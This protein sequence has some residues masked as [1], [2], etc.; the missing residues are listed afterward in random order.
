MLRVTSLTW[1]F[2]TDFGDCTHSDDVEYVWS[3]I[4][5]AILKAM[6]IYIPKVRLTPRKHPNWYNPDIRLMLNCIRTLRRKCNKHPTSYNLSK[7]QNLEKQLQNKLMLA[8][9]TY[10]KNLIDTF[11]KVNS[12][13]IYKYIHSLTNHGT[14]PPTVTFDSS[15][16]AL[17]GDKASM[18]NTFF[19]SVFTRSLFRLPPLDELPIPD[20]TITDIS[21]SESDVHEA[22]SSLNTT[23]AMGIDGIGPKLLKHCALALYKPIHHLFMLSISH[24]Y[25]PKDWRLHLITPIHKSGDKSSVKNYRPISLLCTISK[26][27]E[28]IIYDKI[29]SFVSQSISPLQFGFRPKHSTL[30]QLLLFVNSICESFSSKSQTDVIYLD[31]KKAFDSVAHNELLVKLWSFG[32]TG[33]LWWWFRGYPS[34]RHQCVI[35]NH[36]ISDPLPVISGVPQGS[37]FG[38]LLFL[39]FINDLP[40]TVSSSHV[41]LFADD[42]KCFQTVR[43][44]SDCHSLQNDLQNLFY[45]SQ[46]WNLH[47]NER[48]CILLRFSP[49]CP[50][51]PFNY[52]ISDKFIATL[53]HYRDLGVIMSHN[54]SWSEH[55]K[56]IS[57]RAYKFLGL[58]RRSFS[59]GHLPGSKKILYIS[60]IRSQLT[61]CSQI[62]R[63]HLLKDITALERIQRRATK[64]ILNDFSSDYKSRLVALQILPL[65]MQLELYDLMFFIR[66]LKDPVKSNAFSIS[67]YVTF[68]ASSTR[69]S[70][71]FK[72]KHSLSRTNIISH[73][74]FNRLPRLWNSLPAINLN[75]STSSIKK[76]LTQFVESFYMPL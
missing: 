54:L 72:L 61:Y 44:S 40:T 8:K 46:Y 4:K 7:L 6:S 3:Y 34:S 13:K 11:S 55:L 65:M 27:L 63:P 18:F 2:D 10:E 37:I 36:C 20:S 31:F 66:C 53:E 9:T 15:N 38:P 64:F 24:F 22:L 25:V 50:H 49:K 14:I 30:Q 1:L 23:K 21:I 48:K 60:L 43:S 58:I 57:S 12:S 76:K 68:C 5:S 69:S 41:F 19:H 62:W 70:T 75:Q 52:S 35:I 33:N 45:W 28:K 32:N 56:Y 71:H 59:G 51:I 26:V 47:F 17:D 29:I 16:A 73:F 42:T 67:S 74:Y 39:I